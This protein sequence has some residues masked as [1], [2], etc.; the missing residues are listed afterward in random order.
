MSHQ[1]GHR[2]AYGRQPVM[3]QE[4]YGSHAVDHIESCMSPA[5][6]ASR[7]DAFHEARYSTPFKGM[8]TSSHFSH[9]TVTGNL[10]ISRPGPPLGRHDLD[11]RFEMEYNQL[12]AGHATLMQGPTPSKYEREKGSL[13]PG[14]MPAGHPEIDDAFLASPLAKQ[15]STRSYSPATGKHEREQSGLSPG[16]IPY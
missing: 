1:C 15:Y 10:Q 11:N 8:Q 9:G 2:R 7:T 5:A 12:L 16:L 14:L 13:S 6:E 4:R 3:N